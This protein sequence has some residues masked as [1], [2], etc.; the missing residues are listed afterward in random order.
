MRLHS[1]AKNKK[2]QKLSRMVGSWQIIG[3]LKECYLLM[4]TKTVFVFTAIYEKEY[5]QKICFFRTV[6]LRDDIEIQ[7][8]TNKITSSAESGLQNLIHLTFG[9][10]SS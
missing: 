9:V 7:F 3:T 5:A 1:V 10:H 4:N 6:V 8:A 2:I